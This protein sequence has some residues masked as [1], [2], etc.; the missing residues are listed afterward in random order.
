MREGGASDA[1]MDKIYHLYLSLFPSESIRQ[2]FRQRRGDLG[3][4]QDL[5]Q[6]YAKTAPKMATQLTN[7][8]Y[9]PK[10]DKIYSN[11]RGEFNANESKVASDVY[12][13]LEN[14]RS[15]IENPVASWGAYAMSNYNYYMSIAGNIS[16]ALINTTAIP[17]VALQHIAVDK[18]GN[19]NYARGAK[20]IKDATKLFFKGG[21]DDSKEY[22]GK[23]YKIRTFGENPEVKAGATEEMRNCS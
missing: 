13:E 6:G 9:G 10:I 12:R 16:S 20:A 23:T 5:V 1:D 15:F 4:I 21:Y 14:R 18:N 7:L 8:K 3:Y 11:L 2:S 17:M 19:Y 22:L